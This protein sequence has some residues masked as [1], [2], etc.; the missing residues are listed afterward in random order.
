LA[1]QPQQV[2]R[3]I[4]Q[5]VGLAAV[6]G[7]LQ[8]AEVGQP[9]GAGHHDFAVEPGVLHR[10]GGQRADEGGHARRPVEAIAGEQLGAAGVDAG[11]QAVAVEL[12]LPQP[13]GGVGWRIAGQGGELGGDEV[14]QWR[15]LRFGDGFLAPS[16]ACGR[17]LG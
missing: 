4:D 5:R 16:P 17:G 8:R 15:R 13:V 14:G 7:V 9:V 10:Q 11:Q 1:I 6:K 3:V 12:Q 2:K